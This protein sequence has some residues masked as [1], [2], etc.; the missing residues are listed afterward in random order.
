MK[1]PL[2]WT[3]QDILNLIANGVG[4]DLNIEY[5]RCDA[6]KRSEP[7]KKEISKDVSSFANSS[8]G[9][10]VYGVTDDKH[11]PTAI[12]VGYD[13]RGEITK[14]WLEN[15]ITSTIRPRIDGFRINPV[16]L[17]S[18]Y[19]GRV[20]YVVHIPQSK[21][22]HQA[23]DHRFYKRFNFKAEP[24]EEY[25]I[26]DIARRNEAP[27]LSVT[28]KLAEPGPV[29]VPHGEYINIDQGEHGWTVSLYLPISNDSEDAAFYIDIRIL[30]DPRLKVISGGETKSLGQTQLIGSVPMQVRSANWA[31]P[32]KMPVWSGSNFAIG[33]IN[34]SLPHMTPDNFLLGWELRSPKMK[35]KQGLAHLRCNGVGVEQSRSIPHQPNNLLPTARDILRAN[36]PKSNETSLRHPRRRRALIRYKLRESSPTSY[37][38][39]YMEKKQEMRH[40]S[41][42]SN[43]CIRP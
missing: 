21:R 28:F 9:T 13:P 37:Q 2:E 29:L 8:G 16:A 42:E 18:T 39:G 31:I 35:L 24:M 11:L 12:D 32:G 27:D 20:L 5:K 22:P 1:L 15:V 14:E 40:A 6:L 30:L 7:S 34:V 17:T 23:N 38:A 36:S 33:P 43:R 4:E 10:I 19:P 26:W 41:R 25:E 3:E